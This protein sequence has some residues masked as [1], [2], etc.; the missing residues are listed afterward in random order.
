MYLPSA[1]LI[2]NIL[3]DVIVHIAHWISVSRW[4][5]VNEMFLGVTNKE[6]K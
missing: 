1:F 4:I 2:T 5:A 3:K 6:Q